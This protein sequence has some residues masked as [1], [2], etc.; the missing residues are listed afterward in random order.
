MADQTCIQIRPNIL[1]LADTNE[2]GFTSYCTLIRGSEMA[3]LIDTGFGNLDLRSFLDSHVT[4]PYMVVN[5]HS[6]PDHVG[7]NHQFDTV[8]SVEEELTA[9]AKYPDN[10]PITY[11]QRPL[12]FGQCIDL[13]DL[14]VDVASLGGHTNGCTGFL[15]R[16]ERLLIAGDGF[17]PGVWLFGPYALNVREFRQTLLRALELEFD[18]F[19]YSHSTEEFP[20]ER[21]LSHLEHLDNITVDPATMRPHRDMETYRSVY[22]GPHGKSVIVF[23]LDKL[24]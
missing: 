3:M 17:G 15:I 8:W 23:T 14:H 21:I 2:R 12:T 7:G 19:L 6:H 10:P 13:G 11:I 16:E 1:M 18:T 5:T 20:K 4:T 24:E 9:V 22:R